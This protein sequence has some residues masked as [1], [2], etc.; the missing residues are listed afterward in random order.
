MQKEALYWK[1]INENYVK[2]LL[3]PRLC[4][5]E[6][7]ERGNCGV[8]ENINGKLMSLVYSSPCSLAADP[9]EKKPLFHF[10][11]G[12]KTL[13]VATAGCNLH[14]KQ[15]Q[16][17]EISQAK[18]EDVM[19]S[20]IS[21]EKIIKEAE[22]FDVKIIS[23]TYTEPT[24]FYEYMIDIAKLAKKKGMK[25]VLVSNGFIN[26]EPLKELCKYIDAA[27]I[28]LKGSEKF[29]KEVC[30]G[31]LAPVLET[32]KILKENKIWT[33]ITNLIIPTLNDSQ[34]DIRK[35]VSWIRDN[36]G[37]DA[38][39]HF[40]AFY[41]CYKLMHIEI[42]PKETLKKAKKLAEAAGLNYV[43][44]GN[45]DEEENTLC[46]KCRKVAIRRQNY[47]ILENNIKNKKCACGENI[48][49]VFS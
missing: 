30:D 2:C 22:K 1:K 48:A 25:N 13:S 38:A 4:I 45:T 28:D 37:I 23:Y 47:R 14:C 6:N 39:L 21:P 31:K 29:Y 15:C 42:T 36:L 18:P 12:E 7:N 24:V 44:I 40:S 10:F 8:R 35:I 33:E 43:Y 46:P 3:C 26:P 49:G 32:L 20:D 11:P 5:I 34:E 19:S 27:N 41:P 17:A 16:N 9:I